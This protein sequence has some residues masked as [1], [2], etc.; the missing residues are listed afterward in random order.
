MPPHCDTMD[1]PVVRAARAAL[2]EGNVNLVLPWVPRR[3]EGELKRAFKET[4]SARRQ[5]RQAQKVADRWFFETAVRMHRA[6]EG[7]PFTGIKP[8][9][10][11]WGPVVPLAD[12][13]VE[14]GDA[15]EVISLLKHTVEEELQ[16]R[17]EAAVS[18]KSYDVNDVAAARE[19]VHAVLGFVLYAHHLYTFARHGETHGEE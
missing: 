17:F 7:M 19:Y 5:G 1:G 3:A 11:D 2:E 13:A 12:R 10:L 14:T 18:R 9:G 15:S 6:G 16:E 4:L 8:A